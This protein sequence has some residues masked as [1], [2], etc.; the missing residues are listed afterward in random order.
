MKIKA[1]TVTLISGLLIA[2]LLVASVPSL[3][4]DSEFPQPQWSRTYGRNI[5]YTIDGY[6]VTAQ[7][8]GFVV[9]QTNDGGYAVIG[10][11]VDHHYAPHTGGVSNTSVAFIK[12]DSLG[13]IQW[14]KTNLPI[15]A[16][17]YCFFLQTKDSGFIVSGYNPTNGNNVIKLDSEGNIQWDRTYDCYVGYV[18]QTSDGN[19]VFLGSTQIDPYIQSVGLLLKIDNQG[20]LL[21]KITLHLPTNLLISS[22]LEISNNTYAACGHYTGA[23]FGE[24]DSNGDLVMNQTY[25]ELAGYF[26]SMV[27]GKDGNYI[28]IGGV[29][30]PSN[31]QGLVADI[32]SS[33]QLVWS[34]TF[35]NPPYDSFVFSSVADIG[36]CYVAAGL[37][38]LFGLDDKGNLL[39]NISGDDV[40]GSIS[41]IISS[42]VGSFVAVGNTATSI[43]LAKFAPESATPPGETPI[44]FS[45][46]LLFAVIVIVVIVVGIGLGLLIY[47]IKKRKH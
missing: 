12:T 38:G 14:E 35:A 39:W 47:L 15:S 23:W 16:S 32:G 20:N 43:W 2:L 34:Q 42:G 37:S 19:Y 6:P 9:T 30:I 8:E 41:E 7:D 33:G 3:K 11:L 31:Q 27:L 5:N 45:T 28:A 1:L 46:A 4:A 21:W 24:I 26:S 17:P 18:T 10:K 25:S 44:P 13:N 36:N 40:G 29:G 22:I